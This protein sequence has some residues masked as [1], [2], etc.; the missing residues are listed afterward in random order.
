MMLLS[1]F[2]SSPRISIL[3]PRSRHLGVLLIHN[4]TE[5]GEVSLQLVCHQ[6]PGCS[7]A[8]TDDADMPRR[9]Y[10]SMQPILGVGFW[11]IGGWYDKVCH[12]ESQGARLFLVI[13][14][15]DI[16]RG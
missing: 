12:G 16:E 3:K 8:Y 9:V 11:P 14:E 15:E 7:S 10:G 5:V 2:V 4:K 6:Q 13:K 1:P